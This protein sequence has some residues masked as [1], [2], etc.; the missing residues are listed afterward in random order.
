METIYCEAECIQGYVK[1]NLEVPRHGENICLSIGIAD[2]E[3]NQTAEELLHQADMAMY[4]A[5]KKGGN[6]NTV[7]KR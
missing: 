7:Y 6:R 3:K 5:K 4:D 2:Y 1:S